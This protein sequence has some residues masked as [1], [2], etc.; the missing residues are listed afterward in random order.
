VGGD[1]KTVVPE[2]LSDAEPL[3]V[4]LRPGGDGMEL[5]FLKLVAGILKISLG[6]LRD[7]EAEA[8]R[9]RSRTR[10]AITS[11]LAVLLVG[12][13]AGLVGT[14][15]YH[16]KS[17]NIAAVAIDASADM[18]DETYVMTLEGNMD[19]AANEQVILSS[20]RRLDDLEKNGALPRELQRRRAWTYWRL[21]TNY[22]T[23]KKWSDQEKYAALAASATQ[24]STDYDD[25]TLHA[26]SSLS[27]AGA[28]EGRGDRSRASALFAQSLRESESLLAD[29]PK[30]HQARLLLAETLSGVARHHFAARDLEQTIANYTKACKLY[31]EVSS[32][33]ADSITDARLSAECHQ[34]LGE[35][36]YHA[37]RM[38]DA[39]TALERS[40][41]AARRRPRIDNS[42]RALLRAALAYLVPAYD[43]IGDSDKALLAATESVA[44]YRG[45]AKDANAV[46]A[47]QQLSEAANLLA[48]RIKEDEQSA[49]TNLL[50][51]VDEC[52]KAITYLRGRSPDDI[53]L[54]RSDFEIQSLGGGLVADMGKNS[55]AKARFLS[56][57]SSLQILLDAN[58]EDEGLRSSGEMLDHF[59]ETVKA[60]PEGTQ[61]DFGG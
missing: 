41:D 60:T 30:E 12:A 50:L 28:A 48:D 21:A 4:D 31:S 5:G 40:A 36:L 18:A 53:A 45:L 15:F 20:L 25:R 46:E 59:I 33:H 17:D 13:I 35:H 61:P 32:E 26:L 56:A 23:A 52:S 1:P 38:P 51:A 44:V 6:E 24:G 9:A 27:L 55:A 11:T 2:S 29:F 47:D 49:P 19:V 39:L 8:A 37:E 54:V 22:Q 14:Y 7:R 43:S 10:L 57:K 42:Q 16:R 3:L 34:K 58:P